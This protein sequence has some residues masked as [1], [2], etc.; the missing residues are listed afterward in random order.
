MLK[1]TWPSEARSSLGLIIEHNRTDHN[2]TKERLDR[3][4]KSYKW[5]CW[6]HYKDRKCIY[7]PQSTIFFFFGIRPLKV[8]KLK[9][10]ASSE[11]SN[12]KSSS[13]NGKIYL[14]RKSHLISSVFPF[15]FI[16]LNPNITKFINN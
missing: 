15:N 1:V 7:P 12:Y 9:P 3:T 6:I 10:F 4:K 13:C 11:Q 5:S 2:F 16:H 14:S 8:V